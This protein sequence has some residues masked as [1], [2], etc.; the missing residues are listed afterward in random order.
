MKNPEWQYHIPWS[1]HRS[2][3][4]GE[5]LTSNGRNATNNGVSDRSDETIATH[6]MN[7]SHKTPRGNKKGKQRI[8]MYDSA[9]TSERP[10]VVRIFTKIRSDSP[11][12]NGARLLEV[13]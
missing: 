13:S 6:E 2:G 9:A 12:Q 7:G 10:I 8:G 1:A 4:P 3:H 11:S 5:K